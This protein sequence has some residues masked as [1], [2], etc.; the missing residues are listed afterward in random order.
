MTH[1]INFD[2]RNPRKNNDPRKKYFDPR[3]PRNPL[4]NLTHATHTLA[5]PRNPRTHVNHVTRSPRDLAES[6][7]REVGELMGE[8]SGFNETYNAPKC[9]A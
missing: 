9:E 2:P 5:N 4:K 6:F 1:T 3:N 7:E 8:A